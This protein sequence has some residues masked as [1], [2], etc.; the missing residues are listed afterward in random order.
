MNIF[1]ILMRISPGNETSI[2][3]PSEGFANLP[4]PP[5]TRPAT[6]PDTVSTSRMFSFA[7]FTSCNSQ[8]VETKAVLLFHSQNGNNM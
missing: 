7:Q 8:T 3:A 1:S 5:K 4:R 6:T 2:I